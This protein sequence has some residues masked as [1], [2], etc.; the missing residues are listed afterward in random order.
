VLFAYEDNNRTTQSEIF[1]R[2]SDPNDSIGLP[3]I[4]VLYYVRR[5][6]GELYKGEDR[7]YDGG[8]PGEVK[9]DWLAPRFY[10]L[11]LLCG[12]RSKCAIFS[13]R[14][15][16]QTWLRIQ[17]VGGQACFSVQVEP[18]SAFAL[19]TSIES[20]SPHRGL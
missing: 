20:A 1:A 11:G 3:S 9:L 17:Q 8:R 18:L 16:F 7:T 5:S 14:S 6:N 15:K 12:Q 13:R 19:Q 4:K 10:N 2:L